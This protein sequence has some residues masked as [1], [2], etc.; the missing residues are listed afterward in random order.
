MKMVNLGNQSQ[1]VPNQIGGKFCITIENSRDFL[2]SLG[3]RFI[4]ELPIIEEG[5]ERSEIIYIEGDGETAQAV[6]QDTLIQERLDREVVERKE[7]RWLIF[8]PHIQKLLEF[9]YL[10]RMYF[11]ENAEINHEITE[12][13]VETRFLGTTLTDLS[14]VQHGIIIQKHFETLSALNGTGETWSIYEDFGA[15]LP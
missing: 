15:R 1:E 10:M 8:E 7:S 6:Y 14:E 9:R 4:P 12:K 5:Y 2:I 3:W 11:G 13:T